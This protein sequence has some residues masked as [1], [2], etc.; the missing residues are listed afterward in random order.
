M[1]K[2]IKVFTDDNKEFSIGFD[3]RIGKAYMQIDSQSIQNLINKGNQ[4][5]SGELEYMLKEYKK[6]IENVLKQLN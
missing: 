2:A 6:Y 3:E 4:V 1:N 5:S